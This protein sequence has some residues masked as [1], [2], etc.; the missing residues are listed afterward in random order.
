MPM[1]NP[2]ALA[3]GFSD[4]LALLSQVKKPADSFQPSSSTRPVAP[5]VRKNSEQPVRHSLLRE[6]MAQLHVTAQYK[7]HMSVNLLY[8]WYVMGWM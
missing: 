2:G 5:T 7:P 1:V 3:V 8:C 6:D 4:S